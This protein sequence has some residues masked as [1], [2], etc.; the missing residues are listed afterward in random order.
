M[1]DYSALVGR[2]G[3]YRCA[4][5]L[6]VKP[7]EPAGM[8]GFVATIAARMEK[9]ATKLAA[10]NMRGFFLP[11]RSRASVMKLSRIVSLEVARRIKHTYNKLA[12]GPMAP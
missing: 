9:V 10:P 8:G 3:R 12:I 7:T 2:R 4:A 1:S 6:A 5:T 11:T